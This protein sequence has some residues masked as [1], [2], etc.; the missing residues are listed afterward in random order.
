[1]ST[2]YYSLRRL[3]PYQGVVQ[4]IERDGF[5]ALSEDG[6]TWHLQITQAG[7]R[8]TTYGTWVEGGGHV[9]ETAQTA[10]L[11]EALQAQPPLPFPPADLLELWLLD[12][13]T[14]LPLA[15]VLS[16]FSD[17]SPPRLDEVQWQAA[18]PG[19]QR[20]IAESLGT[21]TAPAL[22][23]FPH[24]EVVRRCVAAAADALPQAQWFWRQPDGSGLG[25][26]GCRIDESLKDRRLPAQAFPELLVREN[27]WPQERDARL[28]RE[29]HNWLA[30]DLLVHGDLTAGTRERLERAA[31][32]QPARLYRLR[33]VLPRIINED[34]LKAAFVAA[35]IAASSGGPDGAGR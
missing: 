32:S 22:A 11:L 18:V 10:P 23:G 5:R 8:F 34:R 15:L 31:C 3:A 27:S 21:P 24:A 2:R 7:S 20:F 33:K 12:K 9:L 25:A 35:V 13:S 26:G 16:T 17:I 19:E 14:Q 30:P 28:I 6:V 29:Y 4:V 1:M